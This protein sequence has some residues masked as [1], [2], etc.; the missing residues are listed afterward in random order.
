MVGDIVI[1]SEFTDN[2]S[3]AGFELLNL[4]DKVEEEMLPYYVRD[5]Y[6]PITIGEIVGSRYQLARDLRDQ[7]FWAL[8]VHINIIENNQELELFRHLA[9][10]PMEEEF[11]H[12]AARPHGDYDVFV[13]PPMQKTLRDFRAALRDGIFQSLFVTQALNQVLLGLCYLHVANMV[14]T[15]LH[16]GNLL[17]GLWDLSKMSIM[18]ETE[19]HTPSGAGGPPT[20]CGFG[21]ARVGG[22]HS[23][24]AMPLQYRAP[25]VI[26]GIEWGIPV[27]L[28]S[29]GLVTWDLLEKELLCDIYDTHSQDLNDTHH[30]AAMTALIGPPPSGFLKRSDRTAQFWN[31]DGHWIGPIP[32][33]LNKTLESLAGTLNGEG[34]DIFRLYQAITVVDSRRPN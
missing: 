3:S 32:L 13:L 4:A 29:V 8:K 17:I 6:Y 21:R 11:L 1:L 25:E 31:K 30:L 27:D 14:H 5:Q 28:W 22:K 24:V 9:N 12:T 19:L 33:P 23:G 16:L 15:D 10:T 18:E 7:T 34:K 26:L 20:I 2:V